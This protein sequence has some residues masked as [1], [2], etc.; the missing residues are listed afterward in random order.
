[1]T[2]NISSN[3]FMYF[4][5]EVLSEFKKIEQN[6]KK[7][8]EEQNQEIIKK[9]NISEQRV[10]LLQD[11]LFDFSSVIENNK[12][13]TLELKPLFEMKNKFDETILTLQTKIDSIDQNIQNSL[14]KYESLFNKGF[15]VPGLIG[16]SCK[17]PSIKNFLEYSNKILSDY[18]T[19]KNKQTIDL[20][21]YKDKLENLIQSFKLQNENMNNTFI[22]HCKKILKENKESFE[23]RVKVTEEKIDTLRIENNKYSNELIETTKQLNIEWDKLNIF[24]KEVN[25]R[26]ENNESKVEEFHQDMINKFQISK[27]DNL[28]IKQKFINLSEFIKDVRFRRNIGIPVRTKE[29]KDMSKNIDFTRKQKLKDDYKNEININDDIYNEL[30]LKLKD[31]FSANDIKKNDNISVK[32]NT[33]IDNEKEIIIINNDNISVKS[34]IKSENEKDIISKKND[35]SSVKSNIKSENEKDIILK[36]NDNSSVKSNIKSENEKDIILK[37]NDNSSVKSNIKSENEKDINLKKNDNISIKSNTKK[38]YEKDIISKKSDSKNVKSNT[39]IDNEKEIISKKNDSENV[40]SNKKIDNEKEIIIINNDNNSIISNTKKDNEKEIIINNDN[41]SFKSNVKNDNEDEKEIS[42]NLVKPE[43]IENQ[44]ISEEEKDIKSFNI[45]YDNKKEKKNKIQIRKSNEK[46]HNIKEKLIRHNRTKTESAKNLKIFLP[47]MNNKK[48]YFLPEQNTE[49]SL[50]ENNSRNITS[51]QIINDSSKKGNS[52]FKS[53]DNKTNKNRNSFLNGNNNKNEI[54]VEKERRHLSLFPIQSNNFNKINDDKIYEINSK[55]NNIEKHIYQ[56]ENST[57]KQFEIILT[58]LKNLN[59]QKRF[60]D[61]N[62]NMQFSNTCTSDFFC[63][64]FSNIY[65][66]DTFKK[67]KKKR[68]KLF[69]NKKLSLKMS[70]SERKTITSFHKQYNSNKIINDNNIIKPMNNVSLINKIEPYLI[71]K[72]KDK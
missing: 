7:T 64:T 58:Q 29:F 57:K 19:F 27:N 28:L 66:N 4:K 2:D 54:N 15:L 68:P 48:K 46:N 53:Y 22:N 34:N 20:K 43:E 40:K 35:N 39:K 18:S 44:I 32:S 71:N 25:K 11:K 52:Y 21:G 30:L 36:K 47:N 33:K 45:E 1:M 3:D 55:I 13:L 63:K 65:L 62:D 42:L 37:K 8:I 69:V 49:N 67:Q 5:N 14:S 61:K 31:E 56:L 12:K 23:E 41:N 60:D 9:Y 6:F 24:K 26:L 59:N 17:Y 70:E 38:D 51:F 16:P 10:K 50:K 72:F